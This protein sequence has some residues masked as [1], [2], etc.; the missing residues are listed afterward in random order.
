MPEDALFVK[1]V[2][3][4]LL[5]PVLAVLVPLVF[6]YFLPLYNIFLLD[7]VFVFSIVI[8]TLVLYTFFLFLKVSY[9][10]Q[11]TLDKVEIP[12]VPRHVEA[13]LK[14]VTRGAHY[15]I[16]SEI[17]LSLGKRHLD[18]SKL[19]KKIQDRGIGLTPTQ[20]IKY[21]SKLEHASI[22]TSKKAYTREYYLT[23]EGKW[24][25]NAVKKCLPKRQFWF[26]IRHFLRRREL[27]PYPETFE[28]EK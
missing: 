22:I 18:Q 14:T 13:L 4:L 10:D 21:F 24:C 16:S 8:Y 25:Y 9:S 2:L 5:V 12:N 6:L 23:D 19:I 17:I 27:P 26:V 20:I 7:P 15:P 1:G 28:R 11:D 3:M